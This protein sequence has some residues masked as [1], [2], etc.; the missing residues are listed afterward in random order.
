MNRIVDDNQ[1]ANKSRRS[2]LASTAGLGAA[3]L[4]GFGQNSS[5]RAAGAVV[6]QNQLDPASMATH[7]LAF[8][9]SHSEF[10]SAFRS[11]LLH[12]NEHVV[13][14]A[15]ALGSNA[16]PKPTFQGLKQSN[17]KNFIT[18]ARAFENT[19]A[20]A[21]LNAAPAISDPGYLAAAASIALVEARHAGFINVATTNPITLLNADFE[22][23]VAPAAVAAAVAPYV[24]SLN[25]GPA[26]MYS[27]VRSPEN[28]IAILNFALAL[29]YL[30]AE[31]YNINVPIYY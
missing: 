27:S 19:G 21:Y 4:V 29:E 10:R 11:I 26:L 7:Q 3:A 24:K 20:G 16:R 30:E 8:S 5:A 14:L 31:F 2:F 15:Q 17:V 23:P 28:D 1:D 9:G 22:V 25:G 6:S 18:L 12:E 13:F